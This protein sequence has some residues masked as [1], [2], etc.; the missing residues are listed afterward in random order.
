MLKL[1]KEKNNNN[2]H[3]NW[4]IRSNNSK[5]NNNNYN[6]G[7]EKN[8][9]K[10]KQNIKHFSSEFHSDNSKIHPSAI[11]RYTL[12]H[13]CVESEFNTNYYQ[14]MKTFNYSVWIRRTHTHLIGFRS[15]VFGYV[16]WYIFTCWYIKQFFETIKKANFLEKFP[17][18][19]DWFIHL[20]SIGLTS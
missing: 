6:N 7:K 10:K 15:S 1:S 18:K 19:H 3:N 2:I 5:T 4:R 17:I 12:D 13:K 14:Y 20:W 8:E 11:L 9:R 16:R